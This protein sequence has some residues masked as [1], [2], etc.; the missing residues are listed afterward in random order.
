MEKWSID[1]IYYIYIIL[2]E[3]LC[4]GKLPQRDSQCTENDSWLHWKRLLLRIDGQ[5]QQIS[6]EHGIDA[7]LNVQPLPPPQAHTK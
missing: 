1:K 5:K 3:K 7:H 4:I 2:F 6:T